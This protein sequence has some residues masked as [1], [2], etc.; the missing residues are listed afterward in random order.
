MLKN[1]AKWSAVF[2]L[3]LLGAMIVRGQEGPARKWTLAEA[4]VSAKRDHPL[5]VAAR[6]RVAMA[7]AEQ[8]EAGL[9]P[10]PSL[11]VSGENFPITG[12]RLPF[13]FGSSIDWFAVYSHTFETANKRQLRASYAERNVAAMQAEAAAVERGILYEVKAAYHRVAIA[14]LRG[15]LLG[16]HLNNLNQLVGLNEVRVREGY[17]AEGDLIKVRLEKQRVEYQLRGSALEYERARI[18]LLRAMGAGSYEASETGFDVVEELDNSPAMID[19]ALLREAA[20]KLPQL[21]A[22]RAMVERAQ[23]QLRLEQARTRPDLTFNVGYKRNSGDNTLVAGVTV[24]LPVYNRN[25]AQISRAEAA[26]AAAEAEMR[27]ARNLVLAELA[28]AERAVRMNQQQIELLRA[29]FLLR[30]DE[31]RSIS[32]AAYRE[33]AVD[34]LVLLDAQRV[35]AQAQ[36]F[37]FQALY[38]YQLSIHEL[39]RAAGIDRL[40]RRTPGAQATEQAPE[41]SPKPVG[42][43]K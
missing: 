26:L 23:A 12:T 36:E 22:G 25:Q 31:S 17:T 4:I 2:G 27:H 38:D 15:S 9:R 35:R 13:D 10:N 8:L 40:P 34:L 18:E 28:A 33:G 24:P 1:G 43:G 30:A 21:E 3:C 6:Q 29:D 37:Y 20:M 5:I 32:L 11:Y 41:Q 39:E 16:E 19:P 7:E 14:K 42:N